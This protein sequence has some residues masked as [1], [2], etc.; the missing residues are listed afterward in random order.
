M[1]DTHASLHDP[2]RGQA[3]L[4]A[5]WS[6]LV[7]E[8]GFSRRALW[9][10]FVD[11]DRRMHPRL[12]EVADVPPAAEPEQVT[13]IVGAI[14]QVVDELEPGTTVAFLLS[15]PGPGGM[16]D[17]DRTWARALATSARYLRVPVE[18]THLAT[19]TEL[20]AFAPDDLAA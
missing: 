4:R 9:F 15:R 1:T 3:D 12:A 18:T 13:E 8:L 11:P 17:A 19:D 6:T 14:K 5:R 10:A 20:V 16:N 7:G 2:I